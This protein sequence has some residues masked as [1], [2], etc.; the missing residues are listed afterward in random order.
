M[1]YAKVWAAIL[2]LLGAIGAFIIGKR[3]GVRN[4]GSGADSIRNGLDDIKNGAVRITTRTIDAEKSVDSITDRIDSASKGLDTAIGI[5]QG[6][7]NRG[8]KKTDDTS[9]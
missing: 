5:V 9:D 7:R 2:A 8:A 3:S 4:N 6:I 1:K